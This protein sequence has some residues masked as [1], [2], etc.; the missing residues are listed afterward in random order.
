M[1]NRRYI[2]E[3]IEEFGKHNPIYDEVEGCVCYPAYL[4]EGERGWFLYEPSVP[5]IAKAHRIHTSVV[6]S[7]EY[8]G[9]RIVVTTENTKFVFKIKD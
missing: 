6:K 9:D 5:D 4:K 7:V 8:M 3:S 1:Y 2:I